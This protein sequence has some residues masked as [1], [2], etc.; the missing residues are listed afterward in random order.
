KT[1]PADQVA[2]LA[3]PHLE[4]LTTLLPS[5]AGVA[6]SRPVA[7]PSRVRLLGGLAHVLGGLAAGGP[8]VV[9]LDD[10]HL[11]DG[12]SWEALGHL[13]RHLAAA[14]LLLV[15][16][17]RP[18]ELAGHTTATQT[19]LALEQEGYLRRLTVGPLGEDDVAEL[20]RAVTGRPDVG[21][22]LVTW[23][24]ERSRGTPLFAGGLLRALLDEG[25]DLAH[26][27]LQVLPEDLTE[28]VAL[29][30]RQ[31]DSASRALLEMMAVV[32]SRVTLG[33]LLSL[34]AEPL[35]AVADRLDGLVRLRLVT[36]FEQGRDLT[37]ELG[38][39]LIQDAVYQG[40]GG[41]RRR[42]LHR[43]VARALLAAG[44]PGPG[45][46]HFVR[47]ADAGDPEAVDALR[48]ALAQS[49]ARELHRESLAL[50]RALV[51]LL[52]AGDRRWLDVHAAMA[53]QAEWAIDHR[54]DVEIGVAAEAMRRIDQLLAASPDAA[55]RAG[56]KL[57]L[58][59]FVGWG[60]GDTDAAVGVAEEARR[61]AGEAGDRRVELL[62]GNEIGYLQW[63]AGD[64]RAFEARAIETLA[65]GEAAGDRFV[66]LQGLCSLAH[67][68]QLRGDVAGSRPVLDRAVALARADGKLYRTSYLLA[69]DAYSLALL[70]R[71]ADAWIRLADG[72]AA[73]PGYRTTVLLDYG[74]QLH[75]LAGELAACCQTFSDQLAWAGGH[76]RR[77][78]LGA[79]VAAISAAERDDARLARE[80]VGAAAAVA[81]GR[82]TRPQS[83]Q[84]RWAA[85]VTA[86]LEGDAARAAGELAAAGR[87]QRDG[88]WGA[89]P[90]A[91]LI[92]ADL[93]EV[94]ARTSEPAALAGARE[95]L[96]GVD[97]D[98]S[99]PALAAVTR[100]AL[101]AVDSVG[102]PGAAAGGLVEAGRALAGAGWPLLEGRA[103]AL[104]GR[105]EAA[106]GRRDRAVDLLGE[107]VRRFDQCGAAVRRSWARDDL[108]RLGARGRRAGSAVSGPAALTK[109]EREV[110]RAA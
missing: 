58:A 79:C 12:S 107:A 31:L 108:R 27:A 15:L 70:G 96:E 95:L 25:A 39:P 21:D 71:M 57:N 63:I 98:G 73:H 86:W 90:F 1:R 94:A 78:A 19:L 51:D 68:L 48:E 16:A 74:M 60:E 76:S 42:A 5:V 40:I 7:E 4:D 56:V 46:A 85:G 92:A 72:R 54:V 33:E 45:A 41:A 43:H 22:A 100:L 37:Y 91:R 77:R 6:P 80:I 82:G 61:L 69:Q 44:R 28:R 26:P 97:L 83:D 87:R 84:M 36:E 66:T 50:L 101:G 8:V 89:G 105:A 52:P 10:V 18:A 3:G 64:M 75:W 106:A 103:L 35:E 53:P 24:M 102:D 47:S 93:A 109:R 13:A 32:G 49:E 20:A 23:L 104:A 11:A 29:R 17:A 38:H 88:G 67:N 65:G 59:V 9:V 55:R 99:G 14:R 2:A 81:T 110:V 62:A 34:S 30:L